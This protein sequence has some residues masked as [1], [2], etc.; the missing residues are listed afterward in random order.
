M[1]CALLEMS[2]LWTVVN[3]LRIRRH[4]GGTLSFLSHLTLIY[5][6]SSERRSLL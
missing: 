5:Y 3:L 6:E 2:K 4:P 1:G